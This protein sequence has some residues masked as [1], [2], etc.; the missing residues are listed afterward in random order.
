MA[1]ETTSTDPP[2]TSKATKSP[3]TSDAASGLDVAP[4]QPLSCA[5]CSRFVDE[6]G[7]CPNCGYVNA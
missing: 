3:A 6:N 4:H 1:D 7:F 5:L 2:A